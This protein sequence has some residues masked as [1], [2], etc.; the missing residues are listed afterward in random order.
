MLAIAL[1]CAGNDAVWRAEAGG[2]Q[3]NFVIA[4]I[5]GVLGCGKSWF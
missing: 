2:Y 5:A 4:I 3:L 1:M